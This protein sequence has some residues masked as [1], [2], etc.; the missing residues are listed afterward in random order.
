MTVW[1]AAVYRGGQ[2]T[3][4]GFAL[5]VREA[6]VASELGLPNETGGIRGAHMAEQSLAASFRR[7]SVQDGKCCS[8]F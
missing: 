6:E 4:V 5:I 8:A 2:T 3:R 7:G 1:V